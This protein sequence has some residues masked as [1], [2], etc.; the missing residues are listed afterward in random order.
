M[1][2]TLKLIA[3]KNASPIIRGFWTTFWVY[4]LYEQSTPW[5]LYNRFSN[6]K[7]EWKD[8]W[9]PERIINQILISMLCPW[10]SRMN[11]L[12]INQIFASS[13]EGDKRQRSAILEKF[14][15]TLRCSKKI[16][17]LLFYDD[18]EKSKFR[19]LYI[20]SNNKVPRKSLLTVRKYWKSQWQA[21]AQNTLSRP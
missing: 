11:K 17:L 13:E 14:V 8:E 18:V 12:H 10:K 16:E 6:E 2:K 5:S 4:I 15:D 21:P 19:E 20:F 1:R 7:H 9:L 3:G